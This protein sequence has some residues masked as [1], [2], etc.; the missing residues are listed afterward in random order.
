LFDR[1]SKLEKY[2]LNP[3]QTHTCVRKD[4]SWGYTSI[5]LLTFFF[6]RR[7]PEEEKKGGILKSIHKIIRTLRVSILFHF[8]VPKTLLRC[9]FFRSN[10]ILLTHIAC[11]NYIFNT[12]KKNM[13]R[14]RPPLNFCV[15]VN[16]C[17]RMIFVLVQSLYK[18]TF[19]LQ[20]ITFFYSVCKLKQHTYFYKLILFICRLSINKNYK[21]SFFSTFR[22]KLT[23]CGR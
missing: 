5:L 14:Y 1:F 16:M 13:L 23:A 15:C 12:R 9:I 21:I 20:A 8:F 2:E 19:N 17:A 10:F 7:C 22:V 11:N 4:F 6:R 18:N 3:L